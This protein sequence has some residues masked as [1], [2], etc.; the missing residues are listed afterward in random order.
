M[1]LH[2]LLLALLSLGQAT[3]RSIDFPKDATTSPSPSKPVILGGDDPTDATALSKRT[4]HAVLVKRGPP[5]LEHVDVRPE[6]PSWSGNKRAREQ[7]WIPE[8][9]ERPLRLPR[10][11][12][13]QDDFSQFHMSR[14]P[15]DWNP[16]WAPRP[17]SPEPEAGARPRVKDKSWPMHVCR[18]MGRHRCESGNVQM[19]ML[20][21]TTEK[22]QESVFARVLGVQP[23]YRGSTEVH[24]HDDGKLYR[25]RPNPWPRKNVK[26]WRKQLEGWRQE[27]DFKKKHPDVHDPVVPNPHE[28]RYVF[29]DPPPF[30]HLPDHVERELWKDPSLGSF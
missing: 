25:V 6:A 9:G 10:L 14:A 13:G 2:P 20:P 27:R 21:Q 26:A 28:Y 15:G 29:G 7:E 3:S 4:N 24:I 23:P 16:F 18:V 22:P 19:D 5:P 1:K 30:G 8:Q 12:W 17:P 11:K